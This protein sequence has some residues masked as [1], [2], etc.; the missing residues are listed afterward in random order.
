MLRSHRRGHAPLQAA[1]PAALR[2]VLRVHATELLPCRPQLLCVYCVYC[3]CATV[4]L[5]ESE[6]AAPQAVGCWGVLKG[7]PPAGSGGARPR[8]LHRC[9]LALHHRR[10][11]LLRR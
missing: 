9:L 1:A 10:C 11:S 7:H 5:A 2:A 3:V 4:R 8:L 6:S